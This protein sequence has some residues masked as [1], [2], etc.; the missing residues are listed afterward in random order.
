MVARAFAVMMILLIA[1]LALLLVGG[2]MLVR[3]AT[4]LARSLGVSQLAIGLTVVAF[5][6]SAPELAVN[7]IAAWNGRGDISFGN[8]FG[9]NMANIGLIVGCTAL[10]KAISIQ[11]SFVS[12]ELP[13]MLVFEPRQLK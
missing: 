10:I 7:S 8:I 3:G 13:M 6:T 9:S 11:R 2:D 12:R 1:G 4:G 5:G